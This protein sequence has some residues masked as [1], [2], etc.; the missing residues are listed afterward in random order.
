M[1]HDDGDPQPRDHRPDE[2]HPRDV[3]P[4]HPHLARLRIAGIG[5]LAVVLLAATAALI[6]ARQE[7]R[8]DE[9]FAVMAEGEGDPI[10][11]VA[12]PVDVDVDRET[13]PLR[14]TPA[15]SAPR[16]APRSSGAESPEATGPEG[17]REVDVE[18]RTP[19][20]PNEEAPSDDE[21]SAEA[22]DQHPESPEG[23]AGE[24]VVVPVDEPVQMMGVTWAGSPGAELRWRARVDGEWTDWNEEHDL[25]EE[26]PDMSDR[27]GVG[28][29]YLDGE[30][31]TDLEIALPEE[32]LE[33]ARVELL[34]WDPETLPDPDAAEGDDPAP[35]V[36]GRSDAVPMAEPAKAPPPVGIAPKPEI[37]ARSAWTTRG[38]KTTN[39]GCSG[40]PSYVK[41][42][43]HAVVHHSVNSNSY[44]AREVPAIMTAIYVFHTDGRGWCDF[45]YNY[46]IDRF[47][48]IWQGRSGDMD[49]VTIGGHSAGFN[50]ESVGVV[51]LGQHE[52]GESPAAVQPTAD[53]LN[54]LQAL[55]AW[56]LSSNGIS[57]TAQVSVVAGSGSPRHPPGK[58]VRLPAISGHRDVAYTSCP[59]DH[60]Q[61]QLRSVRTGAA[62]RIPAPP[63]PATDGWWT[64]FA[65]SATFSDR[66]ARD[67]LG[68]AATAAERA[69]AENQ[70]E[71]TGGPAGPILWFATR[72]SVT[73]T[74]DPAVRLHLAWPGRAPTAAELTTRRDRLRAGASR[75]TVAGEHLAATGAGDVDDQTFVSQL[76]ENVTG[77]PIDP[78]T[79]AELLDRL[80]S[81]TSRAALLVEYAER[82]DHVSATED[83]VRVIVVHHAMLGTIPAGPEIDRWVAESPAAL[84]THIVT[85]AS[86]RSRIGG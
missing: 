78:Q 9:T 51:F 70:F 8:P 38:W 84:A 81:G 59:G 27:S 4:S 11:V 24:I 28:P 66:Q 39:S 16:I 21:G 22:P 50:S 33:D 7:D 26:T 17:D 2:H 47:G 63:A 37:R 5:L 31:A 86:Y 57:P 68:R 40:G 55:L 18:D 62:A 74:T 36:E 85:S 23:S 76:H 12:S 43:R 83:R 41:T 58:A 56:K 20:E 52:P 46:A 25:V 71:R 45:A 54:A 61:D 49:R 60:L 34:R 79:R 30:G 65:D 19:E 3:P 13:V 80:A 29:I 77:S 73:T 14:T 32:P 72:P 44:P 15:R 42:L 35:A 48:R 67:F 1:R 6:G 82:S 53:Q 69:G 64:P 75:A 10:P